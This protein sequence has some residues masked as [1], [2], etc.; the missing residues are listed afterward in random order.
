MKM[1]KGDYDMADI[2]ADLHHRLGHNEY[3]GDHIR[4][5]YIDEVQDLTMSQIALLKHVCRNVETG[6]VFCGDTAQTIARGID[7]RFED[8]KSLFY[9]KFMPESERS[10]YNQGK[11]NAKVSETFVL[12]QNFRTHT[13]VLKLSQS[14]IELLS[15]FFPHSIDVLKPETSLVYGEAPVVLD[16]GSRKNAVVTIFGNT[17]HD[18]GMFVG[19][20]AEQVILVRDDNARKEILNC[21]GKQ[22]LVLT[23]RECKGLEF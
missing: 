14:T 1:D 22:A 19:F 12:N 11:G 15:S 6:F 13:E 23:I 18:G 7:F 5:V 16:C 20:G 2:V 8:I 21:I 9:I 3:V 4:Y 17:E 10:A